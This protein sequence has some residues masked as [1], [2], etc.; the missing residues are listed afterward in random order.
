MNKEHK[1]FLRYIDFTPII[2]TKM[3]YSYMDLYNLYMNIYKGY[4]ILNG[5]EAKYI[6]INQS[7]KHIYFNNILYF[8]DKTLID[9]G[10]DGEVH[11]ISDFIS[12]NEPFYK[13]GTNLAMKITP[14]YIGDKYD[15]M[16]ESKILKLCNKYFMKGFMFLPIT[17][18]QTYTVTF[19]PSHFYSITIHDKYFAGYMKNTLNEYK[20]KSKC[21]YDFDEFINNE[22]KSP[23]ELSNKKLL[24][25]MDYASC[26]FK[27]LIDNTGMNLIKYIAV[28]TFGHIYTALHI[29]NKYENII[30]MDLH[31]NNIMVVPM[32]NTDDTIKI[33]DKK[34]NLDGIIY[35][36]LFM[37]KVVD[38]SR[39]L[40]LGKDNYHKRISNFYKHYFYDFYQKNSELIEKNISD[41]KY[42]KYLYAIDIWKLFSSINIIIN[43]NK[44]DIKNNIYSDFIKIEKQ[45]YETITDGIIGKHNIE[46]FDAT[47]LLHKYM[48]NFIKIDNIRKKKPIMEIK[49]S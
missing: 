7:R 30:H 6:F 12:K 8:R 24:N 13:N 33:S 48:A 17:F 47:N 5:I 2:P 18:V 44:N 40:I 34:Y 41:K 26:T 21:K 29:L 32:L 27:T 3:E 28:S 43:N 15:N 11:I 31:V 45:S 1:I 14:M 10:A 16:L 38:F 23:K 9:Y 20:E 25:I 42:W 4:N 22:L 37:C 49:L 36:H 35:I 19:L 46:I 39:S